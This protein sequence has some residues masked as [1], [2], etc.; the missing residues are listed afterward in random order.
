MISNLCI[1]FTICIFIL[2]KDYYVFYRYELYYGGKT[3][4]DGVAGIAFVSGACGY[5]RTSVQ[6]DG[7][8]FV[9]TSV[10]AH[11]LGHK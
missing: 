2:F 11:E 9:L 3:E 7:N 4:N 8:Y 6:E 1:H 10:A 5:Y